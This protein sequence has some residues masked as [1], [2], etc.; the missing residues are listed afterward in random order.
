MHDYP[1]LYAQAQ[2]VVQSAEQIAFIVQERIR[3]RHA[4]T[5]LSQG[6]CAFRENSRNS[7]DSH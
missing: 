2:P 7:H 1:P 6:Q 4:L 3:P 5:Y